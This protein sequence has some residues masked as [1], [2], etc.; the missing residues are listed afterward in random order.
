VLEALATKLGNLDL[1]KGSDKAS[2]NSNSRSSKSGNAS[3]ANTDTV[4]ETPA[5]FEGETT[6]N[7]Q[8]E[9]AR[10][11]LEKAVGSTPSMGQNA[12]VKAALTSLQGM[13]SKQNQP[14]LTT[15]EPQPLINRALAAIDST[16]LER[17]SWDQIEDILEQATS[18]P[19]APRLEPL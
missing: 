10:E 2:P 11:L 13:V 6:M 17:P 12:E 14:I 7:S 19:S 4:P 5:P 8:S 18:M 16:T 15:N 9:Y 3:N 1:S